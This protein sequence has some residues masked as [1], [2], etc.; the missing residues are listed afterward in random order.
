[1]CC[2]AISSHDSSNPAATKSDRKIIPWLAVQIGIRASAA[3]MRSLIN[4]K[5]DLL[6]EGR[7]FEILAS[8]CAYA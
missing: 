6:S 2:C 8:E 5:Y 3:L 1:M 7:S 4:L